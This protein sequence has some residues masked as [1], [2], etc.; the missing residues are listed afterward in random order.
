MLPGIKR[1]PFRA[2]GGTGTIT[3]HDVNGAEDAFGAAFS[4]VV[5]IEGRY[6]RYLPT[7]FLSEINGVSIQGG[8]IELDEETSGLLDFAFAC[9]EKSDGL[10]DITSGILRKAWRFDGSA[11]PSEE[12]LSGLIGR[13]GL[14]KLSW[15]KPVLSFPTPG[16]ELDFGGIGKEYAVDR[17]IDTLRSLGFEHALVEMAGDIRACGALPD[18][19]PWRV[20]VLDPRA[21]ESCENIVKLS[22][23]GIAT[24][25]NYARGIT[26]GGRRYGH[27]LNP[28]TGWPVEGM[29]SVTVVAPTCMAAGAI[30][31]IG[32]L[33]GA[34]GASWLRASGFS[35]GWYNHDGESGGDLFVQA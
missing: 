8:S 7:S 18:G 10:F 14:L 15:Q 25:G 6:S 2:M 35:H 13:I 4:E 16:L 30:A 22:D 12:T 20:A 33:K 19:S 1:F 31:S 29:A 23:S 17:C 9:Y 11:I 5:R 34:E 32:M 28:K 21:Q 3:L 24:S 26:V 27:L